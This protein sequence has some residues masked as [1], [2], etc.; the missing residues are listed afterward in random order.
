[1]KDGLGG[2]IGV[3]LGAIVFGWFFGV[4]FGVSIIIVIVLGAVAVAAMVAIAKVIAYLKQRYL[5]NALTDSNRYY[6][7]G[8]SLMAR[9]VSA[10]LPFADTFP[11]YVFEIGAL[12]R[13][14]VDTGKVWFHGDK[15]LSYKDL[16]VDNEGDNVVSF[17]AGET[18]AEDRLIVSVLFRYQN[19]PGGVSDYAI[20]RHH[21]LL[22]T[23]GSGVGFVLKHKAVGPQSIYFMKLTE[24]RKFALFYSSDPQELA[25]FIEK[26]MKAIVKREAT[27]IK[28]FEEAQASAKVKRRRIEN[29]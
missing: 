29:Y 16:G 1:M 15:Q 21:L 7:D 2:A 23:L 10:V 12:E 20:D 11:N 17:E 26:Y 8:R 28:K 24:M 22:V 18:A 27:S 5:T 14:N 3:L 6:L 25:G 4:V 9:A 19:A 13:S